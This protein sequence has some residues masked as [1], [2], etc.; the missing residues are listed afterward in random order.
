MPSSLLATA[1]R[2]NSRPS[3]LPPAALSHWQE[4]RS[5]HA[6]LT[7]FVLD[8]F[9]ADHPKDSVLHSGATIALAIIDFLKLCI[10]AS[11]NRGMP[12][13]QGWPP[14]STSQAAVEASRGL[15]VCWVL[16]KS[17]AAQVL[18]WVP[19]PGDD[20][21]GDCSELSGGSVAG[22]SEVPWARLKKAMVQVKETTCVGYTEAPANA[23]FG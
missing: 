22:D 9:A 14:L 5:S 7:D 19:M 4:A 2:A 21:L 6:K 10:C 13:W 1:L 12:A 17:S 18:D 15:L 23:V 16:L 8:S 3:S 20:E 11:H